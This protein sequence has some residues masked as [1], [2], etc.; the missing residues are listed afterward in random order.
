MDPEIDT[1]RDMGVDTEMDTDVNTVEVP[2]CRYGS[3]NDKN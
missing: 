1:N 3:F 2:I